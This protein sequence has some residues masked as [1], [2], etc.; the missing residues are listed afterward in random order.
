MTTAGW[1]RGLLGITTVQS[2]GT[3]VTPRSKL[4]FVGGTVTSNAATDSIDVAFGAGGTLET[5]NGSAPQT[6]TE[7]S[8]PGDDTLSIGSELAITEGQCVTHDVFARFTPAG[9]TA[10]KDFVR[11][12]C[13][14]FPHGGAATADAGEET[15]KADK[16]PFGAVAA[17][18]A[19]SLVS[20]VM[21]VSGT[22]ATGAAG[23][24]NV[25]EQFTITA[26]PEADEVEEPPPDPF[27]PFAVEHAAALGFREPNYTTD[28]TTGTWTAEVGA[29]AVAAADAPAAVGGAPDFAAAK[30]AL[31]CATTVATAWGTGDTYGFAV[32]HF[33]EIL[34]VNG[35]PGV[36]ANPGIFSDSLQYVGLYAWFT[37]TKGVDAQYFVAV[38]DYA[39]AD[40]A[41]KYATVE[42][43]S[44]VAGATGAG[45]VTLQWKKTGGTLSIKANGAAWQ[46]GDAVGATITAAQAGTFVLGADYNGLQKTEGRIRALGLFKAAKDDAFAANVVSWSAAEFA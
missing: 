8:S 33:D 7:T 4:N 38:M 2:E 1:R 43:T 11:Q 30:A 21:R 42:I 23:Q 18:I 39:D 19:M 28:G 32:V 34:G 46:A 12:R 20:G 14:V 40:S 17:T 10:F 31:T 6:A 26:A 36:Y 3:N 15:P 37:G 24:W 9:G 35:H 45:K 29:N 13:Y 22:N 5:D 16:E 25:I 44:L 41:A 27:D